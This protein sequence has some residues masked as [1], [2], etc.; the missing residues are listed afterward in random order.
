MKDKCKAV[1]TSESNNKN[2]GVNSEWKLVAKRM[3]VP[4]KT[5]SIFEKKMSNKKC[6]S[7]RL[8]KDGCFNYS[9]S[10]HFLG[11]CPQLKKPNVTPDSHDALICSPVM[12]SY[13]DTHFLVDSGC[14]DYMH[15]VE[16]SLEVP[17]DFSW[18]QVSIHE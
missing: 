10:D 9:N 17:L 12:L 2:V 6:S 7:H 5:S 16:R 3:K 13:S 1:A 15:G 18:K 14:I 8:G 11:D 4:C